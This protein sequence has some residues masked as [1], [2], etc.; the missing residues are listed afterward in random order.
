M[1]GCRSWFVILLILV[2]P[3][4]AH[5]GILN[6]R[7]GLGTI[8]QKDRDSGGSTRYSAVLLATSYRTPTFEFALDLP[9]RWDTQT[10][11]FDRDDW[12]RKGDPLRPLNALRYSSGTGHISGGLEVFTDW[13]PGD[14]FLVR[15]L[16][17]RGEIDY[18]LPG[19]RIQWTEEHFDL[20][21]GM[22]RPVDPTVQAVAL[23][24]RVFR[25]VTLVVEGA[26]DP[27]APVA[28]SRDSIGGRP[29]TYDS[30]RLTA[31]AAGIRVELVE[32]NVL[33]F[34]IGAHAGDI[35]GE[36]KGR[37]GELSATLDFTHSY[38]N[39]LKLLF[40][41]IICE[42]G[43]VPAWFDASYPVYRWGPNS[44][45]FLGS[46]P[47]DGTMPD[48]TMR[49]YDIQYDLGDSFSI[50]GGLDRFDDDSMSRARFEAQL[51]EENGRGLEIS[52]WSRA[53]SPDIKLFSE[54]SALHS[55]ASA[56][57]NF[58]PHFLFSLSYEH[59]W[60]FQE[61]EAGFRPLNSLMLGVVYDISL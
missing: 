40:R 44:Q 38:L 47:L 29:D 42:G 45:P 31:E 24:W 22:D 48:R 5:A 27:K 26:V 19:V 18:V 49:S 25:G 51:K 20:D 16:S 28:F 13:T 9:L 30:E 7:S 6:L 39:R 54:D 43:Y 60:A 2:M 50:S 35:N 8:A 59:S 52:I 14:G 21:A 33:D 58:L 34:G 15:D 12:N 53:D 3:F 11:E 37:G 36:A 17:G 41:S 56:L 57:Y 23:T 4:G 32:G 55:R 46:N 61:E 10:W 1:P